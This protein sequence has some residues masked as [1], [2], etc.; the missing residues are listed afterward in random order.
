MFNVASSASWRSAGTF[1]IPES[2]LHCMNYS[3]TSQVSDHIWSQ[4]LEDC[5]SDNML[6][7]SVYRTPHGVV[8]VSMGPCEIL[9]SGGKCTTMKE[10]MLPRHFVDHESHIVS[11]DQ[12]RPYA[13]QCLTVRAIRRNSME[14]CS[15]G[16]AASCADTQKLPRI[17]WNPKVQYPPRGHILSQ[18]N[19]IHT[20]PTHLFKIPF[21]ITRPS[22]SWSS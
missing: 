10:N 3:V 6:L 12:M 22:T 2:T 1:L 11:R 16:E 14:L 20:T 8:W 19:P 5:R 15:S 9:I 17:L 4:E 13:G 18:I 21:N 7:A